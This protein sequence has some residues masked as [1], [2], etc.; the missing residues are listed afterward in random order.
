MCYI[1]KYLPS[2]KNHK[3]VTLE[4][5]PHLLMQGCCVPDRCVPDRKFLDVAPLNKASLGYFA[6]DRCVPTLD[7]I[8]HGT[9]SIGHYRGLGRPPAKMDQ[10]GV[11]PASPTPLT[12]F[13][14]S[15]LNLGLGWF[16]QGQNSQGTLYPRDATS[17]RFR[18]GTH[19][20]GTD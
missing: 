14:Q 8:K 20:S 6:P 3:A 15:N 1:L 17:N 5:Y 12:R 7:R 16:S 19:R 4:S 11:W 10:W 2:E 18:S 9:C 13:A